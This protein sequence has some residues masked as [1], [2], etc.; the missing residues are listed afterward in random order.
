MTVD[1]WDPMV[2]AEEAQAEYGIT[3]IAAPEAESYDGI[4]LAVAHDQF[5]DLGTQG[6]R[7]L[8]REGHVLYDLKHVLP[9]D[10]ADLR[11]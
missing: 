6:L 9:R 7:A 4:V 1:V 5:R 2:D 3:P 8:G 10:A 11:L